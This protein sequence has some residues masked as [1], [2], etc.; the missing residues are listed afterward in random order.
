MLILKIKHRLGYKQGLKTTQKNVKIS[1]VG[2]NVTSNLTFNIKL[3]AS[4]ENTALQVTW[5]I[6]MFMK[7]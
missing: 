2:L 5:T 6:K 7:I 1:K 3:L 4:C